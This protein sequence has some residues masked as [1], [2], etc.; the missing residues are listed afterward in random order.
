MF[1]ALRALRIF[2][3]VKVTLTPTLTPTLIPT[4]TLTLTLTLTPNQV[5]NNVRMP[6]VFEEVLDG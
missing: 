2:K 1:R 5:I 3:L 6:Q 4:L